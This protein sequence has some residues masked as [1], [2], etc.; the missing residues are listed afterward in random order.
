MKVPLYLFISLILLST[1]LLAQNQVPQ[2]AKGAVWYQI[3][4]ERFRNA[5]SANDPIA[6]RVVGNRFEDWQVHPWASNWYK[7]Q[8]WEQ[9]RGDKF[10]DLIWDRRYG[11]DLV[12]VI[13][14]L[15]YLKE[16][17]IDVIYFNPVFE[18]PSLHKYDA[19]TYHHIENNF[20]N[21]REGDWKV[22]QK[23][24]DDPSTW[25]FTSADKV[26]LDLI[27]KAHE[28]GIKVVIDGVFNHCGTEFWAFQDIVKN[29]QKSAY[30]DWFDVVSWDNPATPD[31]NE[32][33]YKGWWGYKGLPEFK[34]DEN[35]LVEPVKQYVFNITRRWMDPNSDGDP[36]DGIDGWR[37]DVANEVHEKFWQAWY[38]LVKS[39]NPQAITVAELWDEASERIKSKQFDTTMN[40]PF[41]YA[42]VDFFI[43]DSTRISVS[44]F[45]ETLAHLR[46]IYPAETNHILMN[47]LDS[48]DTDRL[49]SMI[50]NPDRS[51]Y[52]REASIGHKPIYDPR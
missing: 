34:E 49:A 50:R 12:G 47:L 32:F 15:D 4:P 38:Q 37:L 6:E 52:T 46:K 18:G 10:Y 29:Q 21:D 13:E 1:N 5:S 17:G 45:D 44:K 16:L 30:K 25:T 33:D 39:L 35:G 42:V 24:K 27:S 40:Y 23:E 20:G 43:D 28:L 26:F 3:F 31:T 22:M 41:A 9:T 7:L 48:H 2:W 8:S 14:K 11:G 36:S 19:S 51:Y